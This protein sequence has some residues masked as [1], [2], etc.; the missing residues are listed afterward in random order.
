MFQLTVQNVNDQPIINGQTPNP[1]VADEDSTVL[2]QAAD[3]II[4]DPD[5][6]DTH[7]V[8]IQ[9][10]GL[11]DT[12]TVVGSNITPTPDFNG[13]LTV[14]VTVTDDGIFPGPLT[15]PSF[16]VSINFTPVNDGPRADDPIVAIP[17]QNADEGALFL[18]DLNTFFSD[19]EDDALVYAVTGLPAS[20]TLQLAGSVISGTPTEA[21]ALSGP[22][23]DGSTYPIEVTVSDGDPLLPDLVANFEL[24]IRRLD[25]ADIL[26]QPVAVDPN[27]ALT[28]ASVDWTFV[29]ENTGP[30]FAGS[31]QLTAE[32]SGNP[33][34]FSPT[35]GCTLTS[36]GTSQMETCI[37]PPLAASTTAN[38]ILRGSSAQA[39]DV[40]MTAEVLVIGGEPIDPLPENNSGFAVLSVAQNLSS[41]PAQA[42][43]SGD[44]RSVAAGDLNGDGFTDLIVATGPSGNPEIYLNIV[45][46]D[47]PARRRLADTALTFPEM[48]LNLG[49]AL[50]DLD[51]DNDL[52]VIT[53]NGAGQ[54]NNVFLND[55][56]GTM[57]LHEPLG[58]ETSRDVVAVDLNS[59]GFPDLV[60]ANGS[61]NTIYLNQADATFGAP[62][63]LGDADSRQVAAADLD[64]DTLPDLVFANADGPSN[65][66]RNRGDGTF[67]AGVP[68]EPEPTSSV[69]AGD[70]NGDNLADLVFGRLEIGASGLPANPV[71]LNLGGGMFQ[72]VDPLGA[73][74]TIDVLTEDINFDGFTD[75]ITFNSTGAHQIY[76]GT[77]GGAFN[78]HPEQFASPGPNA[79]RSR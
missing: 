74:P 2:L 13:P 66:Y 28:G 69:A 47:N 35:A 48:S 23:N 36:T 4:V 72:S 39:G 76:T 45:D 49:I 29:I 53:A 56:N 11:D 6:T 16:D 30:A 60:F 51:G 25:R 32:F 57:S 64:G 21:D 8:T 7:T 77:G 14:P 61:P 46:P 70:F 1:I 33:F 62:I 44:S 63:S 31:L 43:P 27:P 5:A 37:I 24:T 40:L 58:N 12:Y 55:G 59:D 22:L 20:G 68:I 15:S 38:V 54:I 41:G 9:P 10:P 17:P 65:W 79:R 19:P 52:D 42:A 71:Y 3:L 67:D 50:A 26:L 78:L 73:S 34:T 18:L 75:I